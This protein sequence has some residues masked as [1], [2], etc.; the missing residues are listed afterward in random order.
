MIKH[1]ISNMATR[2]GARKGAGRPTIAAELKTADL[3]RECLIEKY[4]SLNEALIALLEMDEP[5]LTK[6]V[7]EHAF[8]KP[9]DKIEHSGEID[10]VIVGMIVK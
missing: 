6:F 7:F 9:T 5:A 10:Q 8:G 2:G 4:G 3:A 1:K